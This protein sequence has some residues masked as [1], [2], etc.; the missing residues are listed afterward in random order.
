MMAENFHSNAKESCQPLFHIVKIYPSA[1]LKPMSELLDESELATALKKCPE[2]E[3]YENTIFR[4]MEFED[5]A[6]AIEFVNTVADLAE[7][8]G[9][10]PDIGISY[11]T[12][13]LTLVTHDEGG[14]TV[15][16]VEMAQRLDN[17]ID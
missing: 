4:S 7:E 17:L 16:D 11:A 14:V 10:H 13:T 5:F 9:H 8:A 15:A 2:W 1:E 6:E 3:S 12:V